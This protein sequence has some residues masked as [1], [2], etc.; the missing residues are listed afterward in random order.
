MRG[1][2]WGEFERGNRGTAGVAVVDSQLMFLVAGRDEKP[3]P[4]RDCGRGVADPLEVDRL[5]ELSSGTFAEDNLG[6]QYA[7]GES[8]LYE[9]IRKLT[10]RQAHGITLTLIA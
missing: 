9:A 7:P 3:R 1:Q 8:G 10:I 6:A 2:I 5:I 4:Y